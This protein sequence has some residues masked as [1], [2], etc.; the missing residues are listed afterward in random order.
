MARIRIEVV[1][2]QQPD[3]VH[4]SCGWSGAFSTFIMEEETKLKGNYTV[5]FWRCP[6][7]K[8]EVAMGNQAGTGIS[9]LEGMGASVDGKSVWVSL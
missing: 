2:L 3:L 9:L 4:C 5:R 1:D 8:T 6:V 7:C